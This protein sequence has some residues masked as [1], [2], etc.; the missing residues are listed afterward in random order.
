MTTSGPGDV[1]LYNVDTHPIRVLLVDDDE[2]MLELSTEFLNRELEAI[3]TETYVN[4]ETALT[5]LQCGEHD[6]IVSDYEMPQMNGLE[7]LSD[8]RDNDIEI[9]F[10]LFTGKGSEEIASQA[11]TAGVDEY[12]QKGGPET[13]PVLANKIENLVEKY[14]AETQVQRGF[15]A[16]E[17]AEEG[18]GIIDDEGIYQYMNEAYA[19]VY[20]RNRDELIGEHWDLLYPEDETQRFHDEI[21]PELKS[22][23]TWQG[24]STG[25]RK[26]GTEVPERLVLTR[27]EDGGHV[28]I[29]QELSETKELQTELSLKNRALDAAGL[30]I[31]I[32]D[33]GKEDNPIV[34]ANDGFVE[35][36]GYDR[37]EVLGQNCRFLQGENTDPETVAEIRSAIE[38][39]D[40]ISTEIRNYDADGVP[41]WNLLEIFPVEDSTGKVTHFIGFQREITKQSGKEYIT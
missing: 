10:V 30:G 3:T 39:R 40:S 8:V 23:G 12:L 33:P 21:L 32:T 36:T 14:W 28:C 37:D 16:L 31:V 5:E 34:Y 22:E 1:T 27:M 29:V 9:P 35:L 17:S 11:I 4:P 18:I 20:N 15:L 41:F 13:Y 24:A 26:D 19:A 2:S 7:L 25:I 6:C 38:E